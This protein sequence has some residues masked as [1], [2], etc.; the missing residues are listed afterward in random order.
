MPLSKFEQALA[1]TCC[2]P[3]K[4]ELINH[5][6]ENWHYLYNCLKTSGL[7]MLFHVS[8]VFFE[9]E[10]V[11]QQYRGFLIILM[12]GSKKIPDK[13]IMPRIEIPTSKES[14]L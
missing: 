12:T 14:L 5:N 9:T 11:A 3:L 8:S 2:I 7:D 10:N 4:L 6:F 1:N 13:T